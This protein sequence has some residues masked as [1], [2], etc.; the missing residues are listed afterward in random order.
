MSLLRRLLW[1]L[2]TVWLAR[3][4]HKHRG[5]APRSPAVLRPGRSSK[6]PLDPR[7]RPLTYDDAMS[8]IW[9]KRDDETPKAHQAF[10]PRVGDGQAHTL[11]RA[12]HH[13][14]YDEQTANA[15][16]TSVTLTGNRTVQPFPCCPPMTAVPLWLGYD[17]TS[18]V[19]RE[20]LPPPP[21]AT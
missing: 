21:M 13:G 20:S 12:A 11:G 8:E 14:Y 1:V 18:V 17:A 5:S 3:E 16:T 9:D 19:A 2:W 4:G 7:V 15:V 10:T 6:R